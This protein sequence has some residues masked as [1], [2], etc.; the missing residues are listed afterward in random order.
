MGACEEVFMCKRVG[1]EMQI[2]GK[3]EREWKMRQKK[4]RYEM[5]RM[6]RILVMVFVKGMSTV[7][8]KVV[9]GRVYQ[10]WE[11]DFEKERWN[12][13]ENVGTIIR[14]TRG[15]DY[16][17]VFDEDNNNIM[18]SLVPEFSRPCYCS[19]FWPTISF[20]FCS[21][22]VKLKLYLVRLMQPTLICDL[23]GNSCLKE[24]LV[25]NQGSFSITVF[26]Y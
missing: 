23:I 26:A 4:S 3:L 17:S 25:M 14:S 8:L 18:L 5:C 22:L 13:E 7:Q 16:F 2:K 1:R 9:Q 21:L 11:M 12:R 19:N 10:C 15:I 20:C 6:E 24:K